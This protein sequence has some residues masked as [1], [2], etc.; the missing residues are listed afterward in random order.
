MQEPPGLYSVFSS[1][2]TENVQGQPV[3]SIRCPL[4]GQSQATL[5][6]QLLYG[7]DKEV[8]GVQASC[9]TLISYF[10]FTFD[11]PSLFGDKELIFT[12]KLFSR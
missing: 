4:S 11:V 9:E 5:L 10:Q 3:V 1:W 2:V 12:P 8:T 6:P 7:T